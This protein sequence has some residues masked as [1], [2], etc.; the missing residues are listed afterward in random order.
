MPGP[1]GG[2]TEGDVSA[3]VRPFARFYQAQC[4]E[5]V[6]LRAREKEP[7]AKSWLKKDFRP[8]QF[9]EGDNVGIKHGDELVISDPDCPEAVAM[10]AHFLP[11]TDCVFGR[12]SRPASKRVWRCDTTGRKP[13]AL[14]GEDGKNIVELR[15]RH[16]DMAPPSIHPSGEQLRW[17]GRSA[18][19]RTGI[20]YPPPPGDWDVLERGTR[21]LAAAV[22]VT[23]R[24]PKE[25]ARHEVVLALAGTLEKMGLSLDE[26]LKVVERAGAY[27]G[28]EKLSDRL[29]EVRSTY[30]RE[31]P[32]TGAGRLD[33]I[34]GSAFV[35]AL[36]K[37]LKVTDQNGL[38]PEEIERLN[39]T[40]ALIFQ[41]GG[42]VVLITEA[43]D[44]V[45][46]SRPDV[47]RL[48][49]PQPVPVG[50]TTKPL[51][52]AW[53]THPRRRFY[54]GG[55]EMAPSGRA[56]EGYY[57]LWRGFAVEPK[58]GD[59]SLFRRHIEEV[60]AGG[61]QRHADWILGWMAKTVQQ[62]DEPI[63]TA[64]ALRGKPGTGKTSYAT[65]Y[66]A[67]FGSHF[68]HLDSTGQLTGR[69]NPHL[70]DAVFVFA[71]EAAWAND[72]AGV[73][74]LRRMVTD[75]T[76]F[77]EP[78]HVNPVTVKNFIHLVLASN[79]ELVVPR[80]LRDRRFVTFDVGGAR[81][82]DRDFFAAVHRQLFAENG[83]SALLFDLLELKAT[84]NVHEV[85]ETKA[86]DEQKEQSLSPLEAWWFDK[87][88]TGQ[89]LAMGETPWPKKVLYD[90]LHCDYLEFV[91][92]FFPNDHNPRGL[93]GQLGKF[94][95]T[96]APG[97]R[98]REMF[99]GKREMFR[100]LP[101]LERCREI[102]KREA[103]LSD[104]YG[105]DEE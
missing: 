69:F 80:Q 31:G 18:D 71:D 92:R 63:G 37:A 87:L 44:G 45:R 35:T 33:E 40:H 93:R 17:Y 25:G 81:A 51:G 74:A 55:I 56:R 6:P 61:N 76:L 5:V 66:G 82:G 97:T 12:E 99:G 104:E 65:W 73:G 96:Y 23:R 91:K 54:P 84:V 79:S 68:L 41:Q 53:L 1:A 90:A 27:A 11:L 67:L 34:C 10:A 14:E 39:Q 58:R 30:E 75:Q 89:L 78:K 83:L 29:L 77:I 9:R 42:D 52:Q 36:K 49:Y 64:I 24:W 19:G 48:L 94:L 15:V 60:I 57:N 26:A 50:L 20:F 21:L 4:L 13:L 3:D 47:M 103:Q 102:W 85:I 59:W 98:P 38:D 88:Q 62:P 32:V 16:Q 70:R 101:S 2:A 72:R 7:Y 86:G 28:D 100:E 8:D 105:W 46:I 22:L 43:P 95:A